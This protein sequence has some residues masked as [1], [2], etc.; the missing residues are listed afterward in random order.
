MASSSAGGGNRKVPKPWWEYEEALARLAFELRGEAA[1][2]RAAHTNDLGILLQQ[3]LALRA[4]IDE[5]Q[6]AVDSGGGG[7]TLALS[8]AAL[9]AVA[10]QRRWSKRRATR[11][12]C[13]ACWNGALRFEADG[14][15]ESTEA[16][17]REALAASAELARLHSQL[18]Q[19]TKRL[20]A[21]EAAAARGGNSSSSPRAVSSAEELGA[22]HGAVKASGA[23]GAALS[24][25]TGGPRPLHASAHDGALSVDTGSRGTREER[26]Q[27][28]LASVT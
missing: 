17:E 20:H 28:Q 2:Q 16:A 1:A 14:A 15:Q 22:A 12:H 19:L 3:Q 25:D 10:P 11:R 8:G 21:L 18:A 6:N 27:M 26:L 24:G 23:G 13:S 9:G 4:R 5:L 7:S